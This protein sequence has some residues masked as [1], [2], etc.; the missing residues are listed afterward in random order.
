MSKG[1]LFANFS[2]FSS[3]CGA[4]LARSNK[5]TWRFD[6]LAPACEL[7]ERVVA[8]QF[9]TWTVLFDKPGFHEGLVDSRLDSRLPA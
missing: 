9:N 8:M 2:T 4:R 5:Q 3:R 1:A 7:T 6:A